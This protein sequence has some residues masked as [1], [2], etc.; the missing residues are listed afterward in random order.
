[1]FMKKLQCNLDEKVQHDPSYLRLSF[2]KQEKGH[3]QT[4]QK[5]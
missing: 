3:S 1:M 5:M 2:K 4:E